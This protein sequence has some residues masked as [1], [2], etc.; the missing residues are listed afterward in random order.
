MRK[1]EVTTEDYQGF[2]GDIIVTDPCY[3]IPDDIWQQIIREFWYPNG[4][5]GSETA[6]KGTIYIDD[7]IKILYTQ[8]AHGDGEYE[9]VEVT[10]K[11]VH[12][13]YTGVD[14][15]MIAIITVA[16]AQKLNPE[17]DVNDTMYPR[18]NG[19]VGGVEADGEGNFVG[20]IVVDTLGPKGGRE[21]D[22][23]DDYYNEWNEEDQE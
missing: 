2:S 7:S 1:I 6:N 11:N 12:N 21:E 9:V 16:D 17:F 15:G 23:D 10:G 22:E 20:D 14:A 3:F 5:Q 13:E 18:I 8:T 4:N 19:F